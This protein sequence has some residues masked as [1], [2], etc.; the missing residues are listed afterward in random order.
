MISNGNAALPFSTKVR[1]A[2]SLRSIASP[3]SPRLNPA[4]S[5][6]VRSSPPAFSSALRCS[7]FGSTIRAAAME[8]SVAIPAIPSTESVHERSC[9]A[10]PTTA[11][12][13]A[14]ESVLDLRLPLAAAAFGLRGAVLR[15]VVIGGLPNVVERTCARLVSKHFAPASLPNARVTRLALRRARRCLRPLLSGHPT[16]LVP[17]VGLT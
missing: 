7:G 17:P 5:R 15:F 11:G 12:S 4:F 10:R 9:R 13:R 6:A 8:T 2:G 1:S 16:A 3:T 14:R